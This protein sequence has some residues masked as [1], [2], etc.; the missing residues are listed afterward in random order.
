MS[1][2]VCLSVCLSVCRSVCLSVC[3]SVCVC[4]C[5]CLQIRAHMCCI[6]YCGSGCS[7]CV[8]EERKFVCK[9]STIDT[10][11]STVPKMERSDIIYKLPFSPCQLCSLGCVIAFA[12]L[13]CHLSAA[14]LTIIQHCLND[15]P[16]LP[17]RS[18]NIA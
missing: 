15:H 6:L 12:A 1:L 18:S 3:P 17:K 13:S 14:S 5:V 11:H 2:Y 4:V 9:K 16:T 8:W 10:R 7:V